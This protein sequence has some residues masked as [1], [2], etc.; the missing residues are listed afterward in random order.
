M[1]KNF[2]TNS[3]ALSQETRVCNMNDLSLHSNVKTKV[4]F[5]F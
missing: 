3:N 5:L 4:K 2:G 1:V